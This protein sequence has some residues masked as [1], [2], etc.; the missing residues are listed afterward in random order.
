VHL[1]AQPAVTTSLVNPVLDFETN[2]LGTLNLLEAIRVSK[3]HPIVLFSS[4]N[5]VYGDL[6]DLPVVETPERYRWTNGLNAI[7]ERRNLDF[8]S[9]YGC[10]KGAADQYV[11]DYARIYGLRAVVLRQSCIYGENQYG[12]EDQGWVA[13]LS[14]AAMMGWPIRVFGTG[15]QVRDLLY[16]D[17]LLDAFDGCVTHIDRCAGQAFNVGGGRANT[18]SLLELFAAFEN[19]IEHPPCPEYAPLRQGD[20][21]IFVADNRKLTGATG[22]APTTSVTAGLERL[23][24]WLEDQ[25]ETISELHGSSP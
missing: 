21:T 12:V 6:G 18:L 24:R 1:A 7:D 23:W 11:L 3:T 19:W 15:K 25:R 10:S 8:R 14:I 9:P 13:W 17:D 4:T 5:K 20:Q 16:I 22:W 2:A